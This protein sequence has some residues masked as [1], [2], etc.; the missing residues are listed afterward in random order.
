MKSEIEEVF[1]TPNREKFSSFNPEKPLSG[2][3]IH[4]QHLS[5]VL[6]L[7]CWLCSYT[8]EADMVVEGSL[9][10]KV[11]VWSSGCTWINHRS[12]NADFKC[13]GKDAP[14]QRNLMC[15]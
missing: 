6:V 8:K 1:K 12:G 11:R 2:P 10:R 7:A 3:R 5:H 13:P 15:S 14:A 4:P 9:S